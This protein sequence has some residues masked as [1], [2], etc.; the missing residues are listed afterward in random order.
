M[1]EYVDSANSRAKQLIAMAENM[2]G[3]I[4]SHW[5]YDGVTFRDHP[6]HLFYFPDTTTVQI[7]LSLRAI[8]DNLQRDFQLSHEVCHLLY[9]SVQPGQ[10]VEPETNILNEGISTYFL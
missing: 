2:F 9:P 3:P 7:S 10:T 5:R 4:S 6:P 1:Q 8:G